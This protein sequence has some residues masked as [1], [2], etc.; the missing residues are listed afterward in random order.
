VTGQGC[1]LDPP[2]LP[3]LNISVWSFK[4]L[5]LLFLQAAEVRLDSKD[6]LLK[7]L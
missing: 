2:Q 1:G 3:S 6:I 5:I 4:K 7:D